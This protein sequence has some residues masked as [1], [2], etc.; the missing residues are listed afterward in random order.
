MKQADKRTGKTS[1]SKIKK[2]RNIVTNV[3]GQA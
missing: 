2:M 3:S 1:S